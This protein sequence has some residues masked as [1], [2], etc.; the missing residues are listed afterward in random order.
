MAVASLRRI[1]GLCDL[2]AGMVIGVGRGAFIVTEKSRD[3]AVVCPLYP[4]GTFGASRS[5]TG[6]MLS[7]QDIAQSPQRWAIEDKRLFL[8]CEYVD[9]EGSIRMVGE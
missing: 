4:A 8:N 6:R 1:A 9:S 2:E 7:E 3:P 5:Y